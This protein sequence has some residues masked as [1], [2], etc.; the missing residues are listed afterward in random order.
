MTGWR[1]KEGEREGWKG[2]RIAERERR[3]R[4]NLIDLTQKKKKKEQQTLL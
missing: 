1:E 2:R 4:K 3:G